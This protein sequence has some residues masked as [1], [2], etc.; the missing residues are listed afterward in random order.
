[1]VGAEDDRSDLN[2]RKVHEQ[3]YHDLRN[4]CTAPFFIGLHV[5][6]RLT[7]LSVWKKNLPGLDMM[8]VHVPSND[9]VCLRV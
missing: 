9:T 7:P 3:F 2:F 8:A 1:M 5:P 4:K 6:S